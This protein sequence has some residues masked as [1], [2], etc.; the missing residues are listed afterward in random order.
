MNAPRTRAAAHCIGLCRRRRL[1]SSI[2]CSPLYPSLAP[3]DV[4]PSPSGWMRRHDVS[5]RPYHA[6]P[7][8][9]SDNLLGHSPMAQRAPAAPPQAAAAAPPSWGVDSNTAGGGVWAQTSAKK[10]KLNELLTELNADGVDTGTKGMDTLDE[11]AT[12]QEKLDLE[13]ADG[14]K[15]VAKFVDDGREATE[16]DASG[17]AA[18]V[19]KASVAAGAAIQQTFQL[20]ESASSVEEWDRPKFEA[21]MTEAMRILS[22]GLP[23]A[24]DVKKPVAGSLD[25]ASPLCYLRDFVEGADPDEGAADEG[26]ADDGQNATPMDDEELDR[27]IEQLDDIIAQAFSSSTQIY[28]ALLLRAAAQT[29]RE[30]W[31]GVTAATS[32]DI[33]RAAVA[34]V[35]LPPQ[36]A[37]V[38]AQ[39]VR[40][41]FLAYANGAGP[42]W[43]QAWWTVIDA[44]GDGM[45][46]EEEMNTC[47]ELAMKP[48]HLALS[49]LVHLALEACPVRT[50][51]LG[52]NEDKAW[53]LGGEDIADV[54]LA[55]SSNPSAAANVNKKLSWRN[56]RKELKARQALAQTFQATLARHFRDQVETPHRLRCIY[57]WAEKSHQDNAVESILVDA[58]E[59]W[60]AASSLRYVELEP[61]ISYPEFRREQARHFPHLDKDREEIATSF[62]EDLWVRQGKGRQNEEL[63]R[64]CFLFLLGVSAV[65]AVIMFL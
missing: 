2:G 48:V 20:L 57:A 39:D 22:E 1:P 10:E 6:S 61:K 19:G 41:L 37:T 44:D 53:F 63:R 11:A 7:P 47:V 24:P 54:S 46:D 62:K 17:D 25:V 30:S 58:S 14:L 51:G 40:N 38:N 56:R 52:G 8:S 21:T 26:A 64:H 23:P 55:S 12:A 27:Q 60:G 35:A 18:A 43:M 42:N 29:L 36:R 9:L 65:D 32:G 15:M 59:E 50:A 16:A 33:D 5:A 3:D 49:D 13:F 34:K 31:D 28:R 4:S 45:I